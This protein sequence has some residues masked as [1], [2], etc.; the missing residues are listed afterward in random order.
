MYN[1]NSFVEDAKR[2]IDISD[3]MH[4]NWEL[5]HYVTGDQDSLYLRLKETKA[6][7]AEQND[8]SME[9]LEMEDWDA[10]I[11]TDEGELDILKTVNG[12]EMIS[13]DCQQQQQLLTFEYHVLF[14]LSYSVPTLYFKIYD[15]NGKTLLLEEFWSI[16]PKVFANA[17]R[18]D[19]KWKFVTE[20]EH[21]FLGKPF[22]HIH[23]CHTAQ[24]LKTL[25]ADGGHDFPFLLTWF[26]CFGPFA[27]LYLP[28]EFYLRCAKG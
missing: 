14:S 17:V 13:T 22:F 10:T 2:F 16:V 25:R 1:Q 23:P 18:D 6:L 4:A 11:P 8:F 3:S 7:A 9:E 26:S 5:S 24:A 20:Q 19:S 15:R 28:D 27:Q 12:K 21:P